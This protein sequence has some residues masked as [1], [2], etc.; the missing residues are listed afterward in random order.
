VVAFDLDRA[1]SLLAAPGAAVDSLELLRPTSL[2]FATSAQMYQAD[3]AAIG[4]TITLRPLEP[5]VLLP[6]LMQGAYRGLALVVGTSDQLH[7]VGTLHG[8][9]FGPDS[10]FSGYQDATYTSLVEQALD[11]SDTAQQQR[12]FAELNDHLLDESWPRVS[13]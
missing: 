4:V 8:A 6:T 1:L 5:V 2:D 12:L 7:P 3:L 10:N 13:R 11:A 9:L